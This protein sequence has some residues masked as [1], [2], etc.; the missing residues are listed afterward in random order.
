MYWTSVIAN[1]TEVATEAKNPNYLIDLSHN[2]V[3]S[4]DVFTNIYSRTTD[5]QA[6]VAIFMI[7]CVYFFWILNQVFIF[8]ILLNFLIAVISQSYEMVMDSKIQLQYHQRSILN[9][10][11]KIVMGSLGLLEKRCDVFFLTSNIECSDRG[12][13]WSGFVQ[14]MKKAIGKQATTVNNNLK[15]LQ[16]SI[17][18]A[19][20]D[21]QKEILENEM[22]NHRDIER[23]KDLVKE[24]SISINNEVRE[25]GVDERSHIEHDD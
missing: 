7:Y 4:A 21:V 25:T 13:E 2:D 24:F 6:N 11:F 20:T 5:F 10:E 18:N 15:E 1:H 19:Q 17:T 12:N 14:N 8:I 9:N 16:T 3:K 23:L 22:A